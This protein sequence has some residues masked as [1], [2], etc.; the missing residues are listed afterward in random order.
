MSEF[1]VSMEH[2]YKTFPG[3]KALDDVQLHVRPG[4]VMALLGENGAGKSTLVKILS[5]VY[6]RDSGDMEILGKKI[7][8][9][10]NTREAQDLGVAIIHQELNM[11]K[12]LSV[13]DNIFLAREI[14]H[15]GRLDRESMD[16]LALEQ[17]AKLGI[18]DM[19]PHQ[20]V[21]SLSVG[22]Q[23]MVEIAKALLVNARILIMDEPSSSLSDVE[24]TEMFRVVKELR[25]QGVAII[26]ISHR[27]EELHHIVDR[28]TIM[29]DGHYITEGDFQDFTMEEIIRNM[30]GHEIKE[31]YPRD[32]AQRGDL[33]LEVKN[34]KAGRQVRDVSFQAYAGEVLGFAGLVGAGRT[35]TM[36][37]IFG[38]DPLDSG[39]I[40][41]ADQTV[42]IKS[43]QDAISKHLVLVPEDRKRDGLC[44]KLSIRENIALPNLDQLLEMLGKVSRTKEKALVDKS[45]QGLS[46]RMSSADS[47]A[48]SLSGGNQQKVVVAKWL[49]R[50]SKVIIFDEPTR[51]ID[52][53]AKVEIYQLINQLKHQGVAVIIVSSELPEVMGISDRI[54]VMCNG[55]ITAELDPEETTEEE[56]M[57]YATKFGLND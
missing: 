54:L 15:K 22:R 5:G 1:A 27:L 38:A 28:V 55:R 21:G 24:I 43:P 19:D 39:E 32:P 57:T 8:G 31:K 45:K 13:T 23:Q 35:E 29:R 9:D 10:L 18:T 33:I 48:A 44:T 53:A 12:D 41:L 2:I 50:N 11:C 47:A 49:A 7:E 26:Y 52:V 42:E 3:V 14:T 25:K 30:V 36:R 37:A 17:L 46:I 6:T 34:L 56:I 4:E 20:L 40:I 16:R 51:G